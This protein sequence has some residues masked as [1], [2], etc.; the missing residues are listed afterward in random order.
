[1]ELVT[2]EDFDLTESIKE[3]IHEKVNKIE[4]VANEELKVHVSLHKEHEMFQVK[5]HAL[6]FSHDLVAETEANDFFQALNETS[7]KLL[8]QVKEQ[9]EKALAKRHTK[10]D[11]VSEEKLS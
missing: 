8:R 3:S 11:V 10:I 4:E 1:M 5:M 2:S 9:K 6:F 7:Q